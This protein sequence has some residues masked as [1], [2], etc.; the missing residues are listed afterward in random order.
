MLPEK[1]VR[2]KKCYNGNIAHSQAKA[3]RILIKLKIF[4]A[5]Q[6]LS[7]SGMDRTSILP[8]LIGLKFFLYKTRCKPISVSDTI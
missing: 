8:A 7:H 4:K 1:Y 2:I 5:K 6:P 3:L